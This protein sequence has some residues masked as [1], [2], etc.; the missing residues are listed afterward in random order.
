MK[1][2]NND[3]VKVASVETYCGG[4]KNRRARAL[5]RLQAQLKSGVKPVKG[6]NV[7]LEERDIKRI[8]KE[9]DILKN[10]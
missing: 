2:K 8:N 1:S 6:E 4:V 10:K 3:G 5:S 9:I 7:P